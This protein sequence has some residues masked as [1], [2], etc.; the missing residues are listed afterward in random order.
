MVQITALGK[1]PESWMDSDEHVIEE[2]KQMRNQRK[3][4]WGLVAFF[5][6]NAALWV[7][8]YGAARA[9]ERGF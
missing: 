9:I 7:L 3:F 8:I 1:L 4:N 2:V 6:L 5:G